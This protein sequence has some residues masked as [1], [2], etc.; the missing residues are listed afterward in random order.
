MMDEVKFRLA[1]LHMLMRNIITLR[2]W[3]VAGVLLCAN[4]LFAGETS[5]IPQQFHTRIG[6]FMG[7]T[8]EVQ[9]QDG[10]LQYET[11]GR[12]NKSDQARVC[13][14]VE[15]WREFRRELDAIG[16]W[17]WRAQYSTP[18]VADGTQ[19]SLDVTYPDRAIGTQGSNN[20]PGDTPDSLGVHSGSKAFTRYLKAVQRLLG[21]KAFE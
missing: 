16:V 13:P 1:S 18:G 2:T 5:A 20:Y 19:W 9:L 7:N 11:S 21:G 6:G 14:T 8:Y 17:R 15:Q 12:G 4:S 3:L 10:C